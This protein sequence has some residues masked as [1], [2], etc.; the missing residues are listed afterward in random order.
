MTKPK[1]EF[2]SKGE[3]GNVFAILGAV[4]TALRK[5]NRIADYND[6]YAAVQETDSYG[7]ALEVIRTVADLT[8]LD[9]RY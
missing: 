8:D 7:K 5:Q 9:G 3:S 2:H 1:I 4:R 6:M